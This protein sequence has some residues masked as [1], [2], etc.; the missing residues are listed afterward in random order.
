M[1]RSQASLCKLTKSLKPQVKND[2]FYTVV[3]KNICRDY[4]NISKK[5]E[6]IEDPK[7]YTYN[8]VD[9]ALF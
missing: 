4:K 8:D 3:S 1:H 9:S 5:N 2:N 6:S 7:S